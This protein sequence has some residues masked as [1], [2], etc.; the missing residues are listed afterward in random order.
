MRH[1]CITPNTFDVYD[2]QTHQNKYISG[3][4][5]VFHKAIVQHMRLED[6]FP[7]IMKYT[8]NTE[9]VVPDIVFVANGGV[10]L[11]RI[12]NTIILPYMKYKQRRAELPYL[13]EIYNDVKLHTIPFPGP[14]PFEGQAEIKWFHNGTRAICG[15]GYRSTKSTFDVLDTLLGKIYKQ[16]GLVAP[17]LLALKLEKSDYYH[18]DVA[19]LEFDDTKCIVHKAAFSE[20]SIERMK[21]FLG[22]DNVYVIDTKDT[23]CLN[24]VADGG[25]LITHKLTEPGLKKQLEDITRKKIHQVNTSEFEKSGGSVR[26]M[27]LDVF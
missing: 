12:P 7:H 10:C 6:A 24:A 4:E 25:R 9:V 14:M 20:K 21:E 5:P 15:Y 2:F 8:V 13:K 17:K 19:M 22:E 26:C 27:V 11:P 23:F 3:K 1:L 18:L 16:H